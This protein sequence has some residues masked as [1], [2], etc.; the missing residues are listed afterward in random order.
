MNYLEKGCNCKS[1]H[2]LLKTHPVPWMVSGIQM[3][4]LEV[5]YVKRSL[6]NQSNAKLIKV[7]STNK[8]EISFYIS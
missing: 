1:S 5:P 3:I 7:E 4:L 2:L 6:I 8:D